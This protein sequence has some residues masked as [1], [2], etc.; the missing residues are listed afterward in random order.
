VKEAIPYNIQDDFI[1]Y[2]YF[3]DTADVFLDDQTNCNGESTPDGTTSGCSAWEYSAVTGDHGGVTWSYPVND[4]AVALPGLCVA[5]AA[6]EVEF[7]ARGEYGDEIVLFGAGGGERLVIALTDSWAKYTVSMS[8]PPNTDTPGG[9]KE[10]FVWS[11]T[12]AD[13]PF[14]VRLYVGNITL[15]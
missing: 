15:K 12:A 1:P 3:G 11:A 9:V 8:S 6:T 13:N 5:D 7:Y 14:G 4:Y 10:G 2:L